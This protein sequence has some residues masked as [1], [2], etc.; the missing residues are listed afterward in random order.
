MVNIYNNRV[1]NKL[2]LNYISNY[3]RVLFNEFEIN[4]LSFYKANCLILNFLQAITINSLI[5]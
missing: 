1:I 5:G 4:S 3:L 2:K